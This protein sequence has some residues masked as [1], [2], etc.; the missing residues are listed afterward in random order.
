MVFPVESGGGGHVVGWRRD[1]VLSKKVRGKRESFGSDES[2][3]R[4]FP[5][6][7]ESYHPCQ[8]FYRHP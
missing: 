6:L 5:M 7:L 1:E 8:G 3:D 2:Y 4:R